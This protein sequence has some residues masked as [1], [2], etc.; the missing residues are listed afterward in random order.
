MIRVQDQQP[1]EPE[2]QESTNAAVSRDL[3]VDAWEAYNQAFHVGD[4]ESYRRLGRDLYDQ[5]IA[6][7]IKS[8]FAKG[9]EQNSIIDAHLIR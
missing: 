7:K 6:E 8:L 1:T 4:P 5:A 9:D 3:R 2:A